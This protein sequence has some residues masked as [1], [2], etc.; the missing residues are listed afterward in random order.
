MA[1]C[2]Y[3]GVNTNGEHWHDQFCPN[4]TE[5]ENH[6]VGRFHADLWRSIRPRGA[7][8][9][10]P[11]ERVIPEGDGEFQIGNEIIL[12]SRRLTGKQATQK[13]RMRVNSM[14]ETFPYLADAA[15]IVVEM[16]LP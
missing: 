6:I 1:S 10:N 4:D 14:R 15:H 2:E 11:I 7:R 12:T 16:S 5:N 8:Y 13:R 9:Y 3:C